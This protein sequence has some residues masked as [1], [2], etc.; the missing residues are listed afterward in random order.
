M[1]VDVAVIISDTFGRPWRAAAVN[2]A[3]GLAGINPLLSYVGQEDSHGNMMYTTV[4]CVADE[5]AAVAELVTG[6]VLGVPVSLIKGTPTNAWRTPAWRRCFA[7]RRKTCSGRRL[8]AW[9]S[10]ILGAPVYYGS[11]NRGNCSWPS[12][13]FWKS[14]GEAKPETPTPSNRK[15]RSGSSPWKESPCSLQNGRFVVRG[16]W[17]GGLASEGGKVGQAGFHGNRF[18]L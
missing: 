9:R 13:I 12:G 1:G 18:A 11:T 10:C 15:E 4:I 6:K 5:L 14:E 2:V 8:S 16:L 3:I 17:Q 7:R